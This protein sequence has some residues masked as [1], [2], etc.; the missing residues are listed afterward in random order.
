MG[1]SENSAFIPMLKYT[2]DEWLEARDV[3]V[4][5][6]YDVSTAINAREIGSYYETEEQTGKEFL[7]TS[8]PGKPRTVLRKVLSF[9]AM[10][11]FGGAPSNQI[12]AHGI[13]I[14]SNT[15]FT[16][17]YGTANDPGTSFLPLPY[18]D[19]ENVNNSIGIS[20]DG[21]NVTLRSAADYSAYTDCYVV[22]EYVKQS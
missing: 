2:P 17:I 19:A 8:I 21:T 9:G 14:D 4:D 16:Q 13:T 18:V 5:Y 22:L 20:I 10:N 11:N 6:F 3:F 12:I 15:R 7:P 1:S